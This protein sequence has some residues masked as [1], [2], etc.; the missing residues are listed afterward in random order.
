MN[1]DGFLHLASVRGEEIRSRAD[2]FAGCENDERGDNEK[3]HHPAAVAPRNAV[4]GGLEVAGK[5]FHH[6]R[7]RFVHF[8]SQ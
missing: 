6:P 1:S 4:K 8:L 3:G 7:H 2:C 5:K